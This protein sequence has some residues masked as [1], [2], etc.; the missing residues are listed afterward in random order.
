MATIIWPGTP[1]ESFTND[2]GKI[3]YQW[4]CTWHNTCGAC[5]QYYLAIAEWWSPLHHNC[6][7]YSVPIYPNAISRQYENWQDVVSGLPEDQQKELVGASNWKLI[8]EGVVDWSDVVTSSRVRTLEEVVSREQLAIED[9]IKAGVTPRIAE[10]AWAN[11]NTPEHQLSAQR[12]AE[13]LKKIQELGVG[14]KTLAEHFGQQ[15]ASKVGIATGPSGPQTIQRGQGTQHWTKRV[16]SAIAGKIK[17]GVQSVVSLFK[18]K[19]SKAKAPA[20]ATEAP[21]PQPLTKV[22]PA[23]GERAAPK[24]KPIVVKP[25]PKQVAATTPSSAPYTAFTSEAAVEAWGALHYGP[26]WK[27]ALTPAQLTA[28]EQYTG[29]AAIR[30]NDALRSGPKPTGFLKTIEKNLDAL[31]ASNPTPENLTVYRGV[32]LDRILAKIG[33]SGLSDLKPGMDLIDKGYTSTSPSIDRAWAGPNHP[34][35][36]LIEI[37]VPSGTP[38]AYVASVSTVLNEHEFL[39]GRQVD[40]FRIVEVIPSTNKP[41]VP[42]KIVVEALQSAQLK[43]SK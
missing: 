40:T 17:A 42:D 21:A 31:L 26:D 9:M 34:D 43:A 5:A 16:L 15:M 20:T 12:R 11:V 24:P 23:P 14:P 30:L 32:N 3:L 22:K 2:T 10:R 19:M 35:N 4:I 13:I 41:T 38:G 27:A 25:L 33:L 18:S 37:Q 6:Q 7:C 39:L 36:T 28:I 29:G 1:G 8:Q